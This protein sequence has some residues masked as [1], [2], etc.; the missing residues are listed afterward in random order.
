MWI[1]TNYFCNIKI[2]ISI[3]FNCSISLFFCSSRS[4]NE[5][6]VCKSRSRS[7]EKPNEKPILT[8]YTKTPC[9]LCDELVAELAPFMDQLQLEKVDITKPENRK[10]L[11][12]YRNDIPVLHFNGEFLCMHRLD[13]ERLIEKLTRS[14]KWNCGRA[15]LFLLHDCGC[16]VENKDFFCWIQCFYFVQIDN[17]V[18]MRF[19]SVLNRILLRS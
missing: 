4:V 1:W 6:C 16:F 13:T 14:R 17:D 19:H 15:L 8:L 18:F 2:N 9:P 3:H 11:K 5:S 7:E 12:L 10:Y